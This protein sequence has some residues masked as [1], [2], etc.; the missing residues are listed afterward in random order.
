MFL[1]YR[2]IYLIKI[3][4]FYVYNFYTYMNYTSHSIFENYKKLSLH[5]NAIL[6]FNIKL[7]LYSIKIKVFTM[8]VSLRVYNITAYTQ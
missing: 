3:L 2:K 4:L 7:N 6:F 1:L 5:F 8:Q